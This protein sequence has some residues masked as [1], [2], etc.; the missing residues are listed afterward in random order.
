[1]CDIKSI[2][3]P[4]KNGVVIY[5]VID[6]MTT[7]WFKGNIKGREQNWNLKECL[8]HKKNLKIEKHSSQFFP[9][10]YSEI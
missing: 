7:F 4:K 10:S 9:L 8:V 1:M 6:E 2:S 3:C 5:V